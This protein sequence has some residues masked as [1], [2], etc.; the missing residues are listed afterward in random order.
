M[1]TI[2]IENDLYQELIKYGIDVQSELKSIHNLDS[3]EF[4][5]DK[6]YFQETLKEIENG[7]TELSH[8]ESYNQSM[9]IFVKE[10]KAKYG[11]NQRCE[12]SQFFK[13]YYGIYHSRQCNAYYKISTKIR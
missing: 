5:E 6:A 1:Q 3:K 13:N 4:Q 9:N 8:T 2:Q 12:I 7:E 10:L 11:N